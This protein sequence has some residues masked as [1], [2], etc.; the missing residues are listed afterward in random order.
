MKGEII[1]RSDKVHTLRIFL[2]R[3]QN[4]KKKYHIETFYGG[5]RAAETRLAKLVTKFDKRKLSSNPNLTVEEF[6]DLWLRDDLE[7]TVTRKTYFNYKF[8]IT[9]H[10]KPKFGKIK[11]SKLK[12]LDIQRYYSELRDQ[13]YSLKTVR[14]IHTVLKR[15]FKKAVGWDLLADNPMDEVTP[16]KLVKKEMHAM[17]SEQA[18]GFLQAAEKDRYASLWF[19]ALDSGMRPE[20]Y[21][22]LRWSDI[23]NG[24]AVLQRALVFYPGSGGFYFDELK[25]PQSRRTIPLDERTLAMLKQHRIEQHKQRLKA[26]AKWHDQGLIFTTKTGNPVSI[27]NLR[28]RYFIRVLEAAKLPLIFR[29]YDLRHTMATLLLEANVNPKIVSERLG[30]ASVTLTLDT[31]SHVL[32]NIQSAATQALSNQVFSKLSA[33]TL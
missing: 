6:F 10:L 21:L 9:K 29:L 3:D 20:E 17:S 27:N 2:G 33:G 22:A 18:I 25:T 14:H 31:Y 15:S 4:R 11:L 7:G 5:P 19:L 1:S 23:K 30:H 12:T 8:L 26:G 28:N 16:P 24:A 32:P 13:R